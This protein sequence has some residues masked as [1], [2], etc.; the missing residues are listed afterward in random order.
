MV[1]S[2]ARKAATIKYIKEKTKRIEIRYRLE[3]YEYRVAPAVLRSG[4]ST[5]SFIKVAIDEK[6]QRD[7]LDKD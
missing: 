2:D 1:Y 5:A 3:E 4:L 7:G 6:I